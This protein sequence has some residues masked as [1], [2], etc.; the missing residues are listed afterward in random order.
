MLSIE[1]T[2]GVM[3]ATVHGI[4]VRQADETE[5]AGFCWRSVGTACCASPISNST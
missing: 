1:P 4:D 2:G 5:F 3:G